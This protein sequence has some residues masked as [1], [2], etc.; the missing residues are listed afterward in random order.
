MKVLKSKKKEIIK[1]YGTDI[2]LPYNSYYQF[3]DYYLTSGKISEAEELI[4]QFLNLYPDD[5]GAYSLMA[6][7]LT[8]KRDIK[9]AIKYLEKAQSKSSVDKYT[10][11]IRILKNLLILKQKE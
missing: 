1:S 11:K 7:V 4:R 6:D 10:E 9:N 8:K 2:A 3:A 5:D